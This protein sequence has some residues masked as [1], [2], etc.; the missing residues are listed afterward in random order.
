MGA[1]FGGFLLARVCSVP[2]AGYARRI[3]FSEPA[4]SSL[5]APPGNGGEGSLSDRAVD[6]SLTRARA[7][8]VDRVERLVGAARDLANQTG[9]AAFTVQQVC[10]EAG[11]SLK[12]FYTCFA[13]KDDLLVALLEEDT[14]LGARI[15]TDMVERHTEPADRL[16]AYVVGVFEMLTLPGAA[17]Y[18]RMLV[19]EHRRLSELR[20]GE[21]RL[22]LAPMIDVLRDELVAAQHAGAVTADPERDAQTVFALVLEGV[23]DVTLGRVAALDQ[24]DYL[25]RFCW[26]G[27]SNPSK[28]KREEV[29]P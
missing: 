12:S 15:L 13:G 6:R 22:A 8:S 7:R 28:N 2:R 4:T 18:A 11:L 20:N 3:T 10:S 25:W 26:S 14:K 1:S 23:H 27:I 9:G 16:R 17:G 29:R 21:L 24:A 5:P 19:Q